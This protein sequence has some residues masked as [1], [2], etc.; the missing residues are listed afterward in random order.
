V[1]V[2]GDKLKWLL[3]VVL[4]LLLDG[5]TT[6]GVML[7][8]LIIEKEGA[9][10]ENMREQGRNDMD[11]VLARKRKQLGDTVGGKNKENLIKAMEERE[12]LDVVERAELVKV[13]KVEKCY[14]ADMSRVVLCCPGYRSRRLLIGSL[15]QGGAAWK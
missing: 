14:K 15:V 6:T 3:K 8:V 2:Q 4:R 5:R 11:Q 1:A 12:Q 7:D 9:A 10:V 13:A